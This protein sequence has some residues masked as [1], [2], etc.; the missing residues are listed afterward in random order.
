[1]LL[2]Q[3]LIPQMRQ[4]KLILQGLAMFKRTVSLYN[5]DSI[6]KDSSRGNPFCSDDHK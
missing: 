5:S 1:M 3:H 2:I 4:D 6:Q